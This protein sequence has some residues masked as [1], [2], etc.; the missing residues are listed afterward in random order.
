MNIR[1]KSIITC[2][3]N[4]LVLTLA[5]AGCS[6]APPSPSAPLVTAPDQDSDAQ[7]IR[8]SLTSNAIRSTYTAHMK[9]GRIQSIDEERS[10]AT[11]PAA[12]GTYSFC[13]ARLLRYRGDAIGGAGSIEVEFDLHGAIKSSHAATGAASAEQIAAI[14]N[15]AELLRSHALARQAMQVHEKT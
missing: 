13:E 2:A 15:R 11:L 8:A 10:S 7:S 6:K 14:R 4:A 9:S 1:L 5:F 12:R 3:L